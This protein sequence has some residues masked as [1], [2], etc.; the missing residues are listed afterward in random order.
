MSEVSQGPGWW[1]AS[2]YK[3]Y[4]PELHPDVTSATSESEQASEEETGPAGDDTIV[5]ERDTST[6]VVG[7]TSSSFQTEAPSDITSEAP[8]ETEAEAG[9]LLSGADLEPSQESLASRPTGAEAAF[10]ADVSQ[11]RTRRSGKGN[12]STLVTLVALLVLIVVGVVAYLLSKGSG[13]SSL[14]D[15]PASQVLSLSTS[16]MQSAGSV[17]VATTIRASGQVTTYVTDAASAFGQQVI[18]AGGSRVTTIAVGGIAYVNANQTAM[19]AL[20][21]RP[22]AT[23][24]QFA[25]R[26]LSFPA[27]DVAYKQIVATLTLSSLIEQVL[28]TGS[29][30]TT[31]A[32][33]VDGKPVVAVHGQLP[34]G[35]SATL[36]VSTQG[37][38]LPVEEI[39]TNS[40]GVTTTF[41][42]AWHEHVSVTAPSGAVPA[43]DAGL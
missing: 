39:A 5:A 11:S 34:G 18:T 4:P 33:E 13:S 31:G 10:A 35:L 8:T 38:P 23:A 20:F 19:T 36:Y 12:R 32:T 41:F 37:A 7:G 27:S 21:G 16:A 22:V 6:S 25:S 43:A 1:L 28:P 2:D 9:S 14:A 30:S 42:E 15:D 3:W 29:L 24:Q 26:W 17:H 40:G